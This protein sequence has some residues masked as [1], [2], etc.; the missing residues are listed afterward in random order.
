MS[1]MDGAHLMKGELRRRKRNNTRLRREEEEHRLIAEGE[2]K[3]NN[4]IY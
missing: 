3:I 2:G 1:E 4:T